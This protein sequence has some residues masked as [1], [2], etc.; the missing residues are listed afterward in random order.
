MFNPKF[1]VK[2]AYISLLAFGAFHFTRFGVAL[3]SSALMA[4]FGKPTLVRE[5]SK[6]YTRNYLGVP[7]IYAR[8]FI[9]QSMRKT[10]KDLLDGVIL[11]KNLED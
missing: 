11:E 7:F 8:K 3:F 6:I 10:E 2:A 5:T 1:V 4:S 9:S